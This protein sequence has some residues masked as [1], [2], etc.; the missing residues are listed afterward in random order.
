MLKGGV[1]AG[2]VSF[3]DLNDP[4]LLSQRRQ[5]DWELPNRAKA[6]AWPSHPVHLGICPLVCF[7]SLRRVKD[8]PAIDRL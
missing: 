5:G 3:E 2:Q 4:R 6:Q 8:E 1:E 7:G